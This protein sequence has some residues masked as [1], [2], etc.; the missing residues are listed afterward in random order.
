MKE[1]FV[2]NINSNIC[3]ING[4]VP[5]LLEAYQLISKKLIEC[6]IDPQILINCVGLAFLKDKDRITAIWLSNGQIISKS[7]NKI[8]RGYEKINI[9]LKVEQKK[10]WADSLEFGEKN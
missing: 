10:W 9:S 1:K 8:V 6:G 3:N 5:D 4:Y 2:I 7:K